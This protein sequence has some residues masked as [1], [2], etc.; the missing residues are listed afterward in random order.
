MMLSFVI[1]APY[2]LLRQVALVETA[3]AMPI[4]Y[5]S[6]SGLSFFLLF[7][8]WIIVAYTPIC[9]QARTLKPQNLFLN[10]KFKLKSG[11]PE[12]FGSSV[13]ESSKLLLPEEYLPPRDKSTAILST[14]EI[15]V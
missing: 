10:E 4:K 6:Q 14:D 3:F 8:I 7:M 11:A 1:T 15:F 5:S 13:K 12:V 2:F 9:L